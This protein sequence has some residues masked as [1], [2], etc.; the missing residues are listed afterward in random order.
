MNPVESPVAR[1]LVTLELLQSTPG[2]TAERIGAR[3]GVSER[4]AR[5]YVAILRE[6][7]I[8]IESVRGPYGGYHVGRGQRPPPLLFTATEAL[9]LVMAVLDSRPDAT[10]DSA[11]GKLIR[12]LPEPIGTQAEAVRRSAAA[13]QSAGHSP[14]R[15]DPQTTATLVQA[16][17]ERRRVRLRYRP[18]SGAVFTTDADPWSVVVRFGRWYLLCRSHRAGARRAY[19]VDRIRSVDVLH[20]TFEPPPPF[21]PLAALEEQLATGWDYAVNVLVEAPYAAA[22]ERVPRSLGRLEPAGTSRC[23]LIATTGDPNWYAQQLAAFPVPIHVEGGPEL[24]A[25]VAAIGRRL[26]QAAIAAGGA[27]DT[28]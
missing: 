2:I 21:D 25:A 16:C 6:A 5:R 28:T 18:E 10:I 17:T 27:P 14:A 9:G 13:G 23:R 15:A 7:G 26:S 22:A 11:L 4:A 3:L 8:P 12:T 24:R 1:A 20:T 19:R